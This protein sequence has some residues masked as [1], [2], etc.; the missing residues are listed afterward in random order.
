MLPSGS[1][2]VAV[3]ETFAVEV[4]IAPFGGDVIDYGRRLVRRG[5]WCRRVKPQV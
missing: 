1:A 3:S 5:E 4:K 2:A